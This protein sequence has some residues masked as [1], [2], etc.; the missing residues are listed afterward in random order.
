MAS[1]VEH[2]LRVG[3]LTPHT[4]AGPE[5]EIP[6]MSRGRVKVTVARISPPEDP[7]GGNPTGPPD[8]QALR[9]LTAPGPVHAAAAVLVEGSVDEGSV[10]VVVHASTTTGYALGA[11]SE[12]ALVRRLAAQCAVPVVA[13]AAAAV[14]ALRA[15]RVAR[16]VLVHPPW[17]D[18]EMGRLGVAYFRHEG[19]DVTVLRATSL[20]GDPSRVHPADIIG[21]AGRHLDDGDE[22][23]FLAGNGF[24]AARA[25][26]ELERHTGRLILS[27]NQVLLWSLL[28]ATGAP[29]VVEG[30]GKL[31]RSRI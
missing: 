5:I 12:A 21:W 23:L 19:F 15:F 9:A 31:F 29:L 1:D 18:D 26:A 14:E 7:A 3:V 30:Y 28:R 24:R 25:I 8:A 2:G 22:P 6:D 17:F 4:A 16:L 11:R 13:S 27:A 20:P 10:D